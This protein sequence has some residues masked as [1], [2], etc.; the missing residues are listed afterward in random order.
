MINNTLWAIVWCGLCWFEQENTDSLARHLWITSVYPETINERGRWKN[1]QICWILWL[2]TVDNPVW[3][4]P[5]SLREERLC[6]MTETGAMEFCGFLSFHLLIGLSQLSHSISVPHAFIF[7]WCLLTCNPEGKLEPCLN[8]SGAGGLKRRDSRGY[9]TCQAST[10]QWWGRKSR[11]MTTGL[12][13]E[14][15]GPFFRIP[16]LIITPRFISHS[17]CPNA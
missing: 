10:G 15:C 7:F 3:S 5:L 8:D 6:T 2:K 13:S 1:T 4:P 9:E 11:K 16:F 12:L 14:L 17:S